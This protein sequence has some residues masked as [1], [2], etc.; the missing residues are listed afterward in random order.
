MFVRDLVFV[1]LVVAFFALATLF[2]AGCERIVGREGEEPPRGGEVGLTVDPESV[3]VFP[4][5]APGSND[6]SLM[7]P[8]PK[9]S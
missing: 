2:V 8:A 4:A 9:K 7:F 3:L 5:E 1:T 6:S